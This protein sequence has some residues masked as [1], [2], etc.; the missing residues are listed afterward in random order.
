[1]HGARWAG[2]KPKAIA[3]EHRIWLL[4][5][6]D[7]KG[8]TI[9]GLVAEFA[10]RGLKVDYRSVWN[11]VH[12][13]KLSFK[14]S[15]VAS[16]R[17]RPDIARKRA[18]WKKYQG[19][20]EAKRLAF[21]DETWTKTN[22]APLRGWAPRGTR[23]TAKVPHSRWKTTTFLAALRNGRIDAPWVLDGPLDGEAFRIYVERVLVPTLQH[24]RY[25][26]HGQSRQPQGQSRA[27]AHSISWRQA[28]LPA[29]ILA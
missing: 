2:H 3:G 13:E 28:F 27:P 21:I 8:F 16:E 23:L 19:R 9:R 20:I 5:R 7:G 17:D 1:L 26:H 15:L 6:I 14:K 24:R 4:Q 18:Q 22:M 11:F 10:E 29:Q 25:R 12:A